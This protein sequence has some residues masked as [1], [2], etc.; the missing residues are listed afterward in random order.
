MPLVHLEEVGGIMRD[1]CQS[2]ENDLP[3][4]CMATSLDLTKKAALQCRACNFK[5]HPELFAPIGNS[6]I[7]FPTTAG[8]EKLMHVPM[9]N[10]TNIPRIISLLCAKAYPY[11]WGVFEHRGKKVILI[12]H[13]NYIKEEKRRTTL[14]RILFNELWGI[15]NFHLDSK[16]DYL[17]LPE[18]VRVSLLI[19][20]RCQHEF[21]ASYILGP[22][23]HFKSV[24]D[25]YSGDF[26]KVAEA[27]KVSLFYTLFHYANIGSKGS[28][29]MSKHNGRISRI[30]GDNQNILMMHENNLLLSYLHYIRSEYMDQ[31]VYR[32][33][34]IENKHFVC[35]GFASKKR[36]KSRVHVFGIER[37]F[38]TNDFIQN[39]RSGAREFD[40]GILN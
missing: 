26:F 34:R 27:Y 7:Y 33:N 36:K 31:L 11:E 21:A 1:I 25:Y 2:A 22:D 18:S 38:V 39:L 14:L 4:G 32:F 16:K 29:C 5:N 20:N 17:S 28:H 13:E 15:S 19:E 40:K 37:D 6:G 3:F 35:V 12:D 8:I 10:S 23:N 24:V 30:V 9:Y